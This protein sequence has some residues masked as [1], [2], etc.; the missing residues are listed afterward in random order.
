MRTVHAKERRK[1]GSRENY[2]FI[3]LVNIIKLKIINK[4]QTTEEIKYFKFRLWKLKL[5]IEL[6]TVHA[7]NEEK[8]NT[9]ARTG[10]EK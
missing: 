7:Q 2:V 8:L 4:I 1:T 3:T 6:S 10:V 5:A 9:E